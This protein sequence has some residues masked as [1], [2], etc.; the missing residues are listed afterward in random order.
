M[1]E[2]VKNES[3]NEETATT[4]VEETESTEKESSETEAP[5]REEFAA[6]RKSLEDAQS[7]LKAANSE[8]AARRQRLKELEKQHESENE[9]AAREARESVEATMKPAMVRAIAKSALLEAEARTDRVSVLS[10]LLDMDAV[11]FDG[12]EVKGLE[13]QVASLKAEYPEFFSKNSALEPP[14]PPKA[15]SVKRG[16]GKPVDET[17]PKTPGDAIKQMFLGR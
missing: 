10:K 14:V 9:K 8:S 12:E 15:P 11:Q 3:V 1:A 16:S 7:K 6:L 13:D 2:E 17:T 4:E 5:S